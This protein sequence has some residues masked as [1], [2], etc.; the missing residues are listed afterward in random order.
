MKEI[1]QKFIKCRNKQ[2]LALRQVDWSCKYLDR[3]SKYLQDIEDTK[4][5]ILKLNG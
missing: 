2:I 1:L 4:K 5:L 3:I